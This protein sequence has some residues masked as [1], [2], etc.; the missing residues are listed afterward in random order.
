MRDNEC[1]QPI[2]REVAV[3]PNTRLVAIGGAY[4]PRSMSFAGPVA[5]AALE[6]V[7][8]DDTIMGCDGVS[9]EG[10]LATMTLALAAEL[11]PHVPVAM[12]QPAMID[13][14]PDYTR[15]EIE[16]AIAQ[17]PLRRAV[18]HRSSYIMKSSCFLPLRYWQRSGSG[19]QDCGLLRR[20]WR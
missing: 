8:T 19:R 14:P 6:S 15:A 9:A 18:G 1:T 16:A 4:I 5:E 20:R 13:P 2:M 3:W 11:A 10:G 17:T 12:I 7:S